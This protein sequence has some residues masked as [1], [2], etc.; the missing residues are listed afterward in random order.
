MDIHIDTCS[1]TD[2]LLALT[3]IDLIYIVCTYVYVF[4]YACLFARIDVRMYMI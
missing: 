4:M 3:E 1:P 2:L